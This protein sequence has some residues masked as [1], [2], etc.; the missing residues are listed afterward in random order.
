MCCFA[1]NMAVEVDSETFNT[2][3]AAP[4]LNEGNSMNEEPS[5]LAPTITTASES[6]LPV[7]DTTVKVAAEP[8]EPTTLGASMQ[9]PPKKRG[10]GR[11][12]VHQQ[13]DRRK[14]R[15]KEVS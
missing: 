13:G 3:S 8:I 7:T 4:E 10:R 5:S 1:E 15:L 9:A 12:P 2:V 6:I 11:P 14:M